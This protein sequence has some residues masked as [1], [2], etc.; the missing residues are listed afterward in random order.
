M[1]ILEN[2]DQEIKIGKYSEK[3]INEILLKYFDN[4][5]VLR[6]ALVDYEFIGRTDDG[7]MY[8]KK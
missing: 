8:F 4:Y 6:R 3:E 2:I 5:A 1:L 7:S